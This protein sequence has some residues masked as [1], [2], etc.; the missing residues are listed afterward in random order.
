MVIYIGGDHRGFE[1]KEK[2]KNFL[3][4]RGYQVVDLGNTRFD[5]GDDY[6]VFGAKVAGQV[7]AEFETSRGVLICG[8]G[9]GMSIVANKFPRIRAVLAYVPDQAFDSRKEENSNV[10]VLGAEYLDEETANRIVLAWLE[11]PFSDE[12]RHNRRLSEIDQIEQ[13]RGV[14]GE[15]NKSGMQGINWQ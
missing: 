4:L 2:V 13:E 6:P 11:T 8:T 15:N 1:L 10:L 12:E 9:V 14:K 7:S 5:E 3:K